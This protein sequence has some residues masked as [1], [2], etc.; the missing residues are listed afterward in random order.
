MTLNDYQDFT[1]KHTIYDEDNGLTYTVLGLV[2]EAGEVAN[3]VKRQYH[4]GG[5]I[6]P[7][8]VMDELGDTLW[9]LARATYES[10]LTLQEVANYN[11]NKLNTRHA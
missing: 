7:I 11:I 4:K 5:V 2:G 1:N 8:K 9:Y 10:G 6:D 3:E